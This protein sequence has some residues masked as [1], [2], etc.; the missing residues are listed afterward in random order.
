MLCSACEDVKFPLLCYI[1][2]HLTGTRCVE[3]VRKKKIVM[4]IKNDLDD[5][6]VQGWNKSMHTLCGYNASTRN[7]STA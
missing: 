4:M 1:N 3:R 5:M 2:N 6:L 7:T